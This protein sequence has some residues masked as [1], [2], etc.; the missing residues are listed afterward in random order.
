MA[1]KSKVTRRR[2]IDGLLAVTGI[3]AF[4]AAGYPIIAFIFPPEQAEADNVSKTV[5]E[6]GELGKGDYKIFE[7]NRKPAIIVRTGS[8]S[9]SAE[10]YRAMSAVCPH[11]NCTVQYE[12]AS[13]QILCACHNGRFNLQGQVVSGPPPSALKQF[14]VDIRNEKII[15]SVE[16]A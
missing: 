9:K 12:K 7:F 4:C 1:D 14:T 13:G 5:M 10:S 15:V 6:T 11:L 16:S 8:D 3:G 2:F